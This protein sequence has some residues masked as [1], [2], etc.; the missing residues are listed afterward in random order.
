[1]RHRGA[2]RQKKGDE[3]NSLTE[4]PR[5]RISFNCDGNK[6]RFVKPPPRALNHLFWFTEVT[7]V[8]KRGLTIEVEPNI[9]VEVSVDCRL[10]LTSMASKPSSST[11][12]LLVHNA[13]GNQ[14]RGSN[15]IVG[16][17]NGEGQGRVSLQ[18][19]CEHTLG[20]TYTNM[21]WFTIASVCAGQLEKIRVVLP[22]GCYTLRCVGPRPLQLFAQAWE[23]ESKLK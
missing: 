1:M 3:N 22:A 8:V 2:V 20:L 19:C 21:K 23:I 18:I 9:H 16:S 10:Q 11:H 17:N 14:Q 15:S 5:K 7:S 4:R 6:V 12:N 13:P